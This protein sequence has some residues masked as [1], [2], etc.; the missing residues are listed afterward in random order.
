VPTDPPTAAPTPAPGIGAT[1]TVDDGNGN[2][3]D[4]TLTKVVN[5]ERA[6]AY[7]AA[8]AGAHYVAAFFTIKGDT[9]IFDSD[10]FNDGGAIDSTGATVSTN[11]AAVNCS[12][13]FSGSGEYTVTPGHSVSGCVPF[14]VLNSQR[15]TD[16]TWDASG[17]NGADWAI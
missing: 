2:S 16:I 4:I 12:T 10:V 8:P 5:P 11:V 6:Q 17:G 15:L 7:S 1:F 14:E 9:G 13:D 3:V